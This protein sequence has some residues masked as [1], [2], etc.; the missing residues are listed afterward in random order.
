MCHCTNELLLNSQSCEKHAC[1]FWSSKLLVVQL[2]KWAPSPR[3]TRRSQICR[4]VKTPHKSIDLW[5]IARQPS[6]CRVDGPAWLCRRVDS[7]NEKV[8]LWAHKSE[9]GK[10]LKVNFN[11]IGPVLSFSQIYRFVKNEIQRFHE[12]ADL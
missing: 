9:V 3:C 8:D 7:E 11:P 4:F 10:T 12:S 2:Q 5:E 6:Q 1:D